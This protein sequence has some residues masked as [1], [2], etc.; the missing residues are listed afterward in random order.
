MLEELVGARVVEEVVVGWGVVVDD[1]V[2][3]VVVG[4]GVVV[5]DVVDDV[6]VGW[7]VVVD[8]VV[9]V[10]VAGSSGASQPCDRSFAQ[11]AQ[12]LL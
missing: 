6:V 11:P 1:V 2:D 12:P 7:G 3:D 9:G 5:D 10:V 8:D 4:W